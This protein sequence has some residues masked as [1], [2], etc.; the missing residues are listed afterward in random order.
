[1]SR[2]RGKGANEAEGEPSASNLKIDETTQVL[3]YI[4]SGIN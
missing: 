1:M 4:K 3:Q 2:K